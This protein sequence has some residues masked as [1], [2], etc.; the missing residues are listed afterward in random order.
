MML[1]QR[2]LRRKKISCSDSVDPRSHWTVCAVWSEST[3]SIKGHG[4]VLSRLLAKATMYKHELGFIFDKMRRGQIG[5]VHFYKLQ[6]NIL[7]RIKTEVVQLPLS[8]RDQNTAL[9]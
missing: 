5:V 6:R 9:C 4:V 8:C 7:N 2:Y 1:L 3:L